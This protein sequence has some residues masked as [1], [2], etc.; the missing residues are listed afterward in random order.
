MKQWRAIAT[1]EAYQRDYPQTEY[2]ADITPKLAVAC[3][4]AGRGTGRHRI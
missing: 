2:G 3:V 1:L 4:E